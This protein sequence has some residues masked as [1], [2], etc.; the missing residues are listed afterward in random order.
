MYIICMC[1]NTSHPL[2]TSGSGKREKKLNQN[3]FLIA[4][5]PHGKIA[6]VLETLRFYDD[7]RE[8]EREKKN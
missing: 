3:K 1:R 6:P 8:R 2:V 4:F 7:R 5:Y